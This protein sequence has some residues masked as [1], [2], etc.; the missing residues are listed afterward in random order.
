MYTIY[1]TVTGAEK[2]DLAE[3]FTVCALKE[4]P[5]VSELSDVFNL[6]IKLRVRISLK[7]YFLFFAAKGTHVYIDR[8]HKEDERKLVNDKLPL[9]IYHRY[10]LVSLDIT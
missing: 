5:I 4:S 10:L 7:F 2:C 9:L 3:K 8:N 1:N 6:V